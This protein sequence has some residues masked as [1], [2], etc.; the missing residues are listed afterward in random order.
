[1]LRSS[2]HEGITH[3]H[4]RK[5]LSEGL[6]IQHL[7]P[8]TSPKPYRHSKKVSLMTFSWNDMITRR[9]KYLNELIGCKHTD[10][11]KVVTGSN[12]RFLSKDVATEFRGRGI[13]IIGKEDDNAVRH[14]R[15]CPLYAMSSLISPLY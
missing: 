12:S 15:I 1:M 6:W 11:I 7:M 5:F 3:L 4:I 9:D 2:N 10:L 14:V 8:V 13:V